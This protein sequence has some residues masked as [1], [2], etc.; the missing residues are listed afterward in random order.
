MSDEVLEATLSMRAFLFDAVYEN[1]MATAEFKKSAGILGGLWEK[2][3]E[4]PDELLDGAS[5]RRRAR[6]RRQGLPGRHDRPVRDCP[7]RAS[8]HPEALDRADDVESAII[9]GLPFAAIF[10][11]GRVHATRAHP[12]PATAQSLHADVSA[13]GGRSGGGQLPDRRA[14]W[15]SISTFTRT[16][17][18]SGWMGQYGPS[19]SCRAAAVSS[20]SGCR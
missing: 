17:T 10:A 5:S 20:R 19:S 1:D 7:L 11:R 6:R 15:S 9:D 13:G 4:H 16:R 12:L 8:V 14:R 3:R 2:V 18:G